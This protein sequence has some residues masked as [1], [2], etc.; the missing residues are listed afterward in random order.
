[1]NYPIAL[2][3]D[4]CL[5]CEEPITAGQERCDWRCECPDCY[6]KGAEKHHAHENCAEGAWQRNEEAKVREGYSA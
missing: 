6:R 5:Y 3:L 4:D 1:M 2:P